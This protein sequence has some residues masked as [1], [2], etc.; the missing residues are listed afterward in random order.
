VAAPA[1]QK[2]KAAPKQAAS[3]AAAAPAARQSKRDAPIAFLLAA[4]IV[5]VAVAAG[6]FYFQHMKKSKEAAAP[7]PAAAA[8]APGSEAKDAASAP[9]PAAAAEATAAAAPPPASAAQAPA[10]KEKHEARKKPATG[11]R[12]DAGQA[13]SEGEKPATPRTRPCKEASMLSIPVCFA[14]GAKK[15]W[16]CA[17]D[18]EHWNN[19][20]P[21]CERAS[22]RKKDALY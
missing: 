19:K 13:R 9:A 21:G 11:G 4:F 14:E 2:A 22:G 6:S 1:A 18:G 12:L 10:A 7:A 16:H 5:V 15:F 8:A 3:P 20:L 17:P